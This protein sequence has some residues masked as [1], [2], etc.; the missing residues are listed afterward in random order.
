MCEFFNFETWSSCMIDGF[1]T[2]MVEDW[3]G[4]M[5]VWHGHI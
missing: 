5:R 1:K 2:C 4:T 3:R